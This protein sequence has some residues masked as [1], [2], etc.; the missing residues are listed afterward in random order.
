M[1]I[2]SGTKYVVGVFILFTELSRCRFFYLLIS[3]HV[4]RQKTMES[5]QYH[6]ESAEG[7]YSKALM[8]TKNIKAKYAVKVRYTTTRNVWYR[9][10]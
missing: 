1:P 2:Q 3:V 7:C 4:N 10:F 9:R 5:K 6:L 8:F